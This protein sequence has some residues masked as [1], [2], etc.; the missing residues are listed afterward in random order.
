LRFAGETFCLAVD[1]AG[2]VSDLP[3]D[4]TFEVR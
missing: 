4:V 2:D 1:A 3:D